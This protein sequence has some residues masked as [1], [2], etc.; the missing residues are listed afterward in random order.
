MA[1]ASGLALLTMLQLPVAAPAQFDRVSIVQH[2]GAYEIAFD[3]IIDAPKSR[4]LAI[5]SDFSH[6]GRINPDIRSSTSSPSPSGSGERV[7]TVLHSCAWLFCRNLVQV[8]DVSEPDANTIVARIVP[9]AGDFASGS[10]VW[11][12]AGE[13]AR[14]RLHYQ[15]TRRTGA[16]VPPV[17]GSSVIRRT[18]RAHYEASISALERLARR[19]S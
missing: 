11:R 10:S 5:L 15:A 8:E 4:V 13:G 18:L 16:W 19:G 14:T 1:F 12:L 2:D 7:R 17:F 9:G 6:L 3:A